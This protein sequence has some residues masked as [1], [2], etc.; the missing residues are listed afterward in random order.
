MVCPS[1]LLTECVEQILDDISALQGVR[2]AIAFDSMDV[3][4]CR[5]CACQGWQNS[6][7]LLLDIRFYPALCDWWQVTELIPQGPRL[8]RCRC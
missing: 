7:D 1:T 2:V 3:G 4:R 5:V 8:A 6:K